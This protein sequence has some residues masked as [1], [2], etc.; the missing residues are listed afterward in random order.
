M[1]NTPKNSCH[2]PG[3]C[4]LGYIV[5]VTVASRRRHDRS[6]H[7]VMSCDSSTNHVMCCDSKLRMMI[8]H[9][10]SS[11]ASLS[12]T[13]INASMLR[14]TIGHQ[15]R[16]GRDP[17]VSILMFPSRH[18]INFKSYRDTT[19]VSGEEE[20]NFFGGARM[21]MCC[22]HLYLSHTHT[23][24]RKGE[25]R[26]REGES[27]RNWRRRRRRC[28]KEKMRG[29]HT[30]LVLLT[31]SLLLAYISPPSLSVSFPVFQHIFTKRCDFY[32]Y[33]KNGDS[34]RNAL[35]GWRTAS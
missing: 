6:T 20:E 28:Q 8:G 16:Y 25:I 5:T 32:L 33:S 10:A 35:A 29:N 26:K 34:V 21:G 18:L 3:C 1:H 19:F 14:M 11:L 13:S 7:H 24:W 12:T 30:Q 22:S 2:P 27:V 23:G 4:H 31:C 17:R 15:V 9:H